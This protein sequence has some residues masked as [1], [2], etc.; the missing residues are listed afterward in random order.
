MSDKEVWRD[1]PSYLGL[2]QASNLGR[3]R[4]YPKYVSCY[5]ANGEDIKMTIGGDVLQQMRD[6][7]GYYHVMLSCNGKI[8]RCRVHRLVA[9][10]FIPNKQGYPI[11]NHK[12]ENTSN[13]RVDNLEW[14]THQYNNTYGTAVE[15][16]RK[17]KRK[18]HAKKI[19]MST[20]D[21]VPIRIFNNFV[22]VEEYFQRG[23]LHANLIAVCKGRRNKCMGYKWRIID[24]E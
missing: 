12:D 5:N 7:Q 1:I 4:T 6:K 9:M 17:N 23:D 16:R 10:A 22:E 21:G 19:E 13:N 8:N 24:E 3:I 18:F 11:V 14:C 15:R 20:L 2:Y